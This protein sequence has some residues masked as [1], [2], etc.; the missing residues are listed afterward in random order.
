MKEWNSLAP[1]EMPENLIKR[2]SEQWILVNATIE[3]G[4]RANAMTASWGGVASLWGAP[5]AFIFIRT[6]R[7]THDLLDQTDGFSITMWNHE[8]YKK[9]LALCGSK[10][11][12]DLDKSKE[13]N[14][15][16]LWEDGIPYQEQA[17]GVI[18]CEKMAKV[19]IRPEHIL[20][21]DSDIF[22]SDPSKGGY[23]DIYFGKIQQIWVEK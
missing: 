14:F 13:S 4:V 5:V 2:I 16:T 22:Y 7:Y 18:F 23:H 19:P 20:T 11:G 12:R 1:Y 3:P 8:Q 21:H 17:Q 10:S 6:S 15:T 9:E